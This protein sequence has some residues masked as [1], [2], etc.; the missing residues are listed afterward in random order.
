M[1]SAFISGESRAAAAGDYEICTQSSQYEHA[2]PTRINVGKAQFPL[3]TLN[4]AG[5]IHMTCGDRGHGDGPPFDYTLDERSS[6]RVVNI[7]IN[8]QS[9]SRRSGSIA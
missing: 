4:G 5:Q 6:W 8:I 9:H 2:S 7:N 3:S 1:A